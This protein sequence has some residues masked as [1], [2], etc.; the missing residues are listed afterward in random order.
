LQW[1]SRLF[2]IF[3]Y[4][5]LDQLLY[6]PSIYRISDLIQITN[7]RQEIAIITLLTL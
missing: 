7:L 4:I 2:L 3:L 6:I 1:H 5:D